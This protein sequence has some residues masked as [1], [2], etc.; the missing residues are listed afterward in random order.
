VHEG[1]DAGWLVLANCF[2]EGARNCR[3]FAASPV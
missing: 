2:D 1:V 3:R